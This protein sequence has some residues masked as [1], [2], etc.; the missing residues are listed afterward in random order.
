METLHEMTLTD[1]HFH[2]L[3]TVKLMFDGSGG[4]ANMVGYVVETSGCGSYRKVHG[5]DRAGAFR[6]FARQCESKILLV[7]G[8]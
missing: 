2:G 7:I 3:H 5:D 4:R 8:Y 1:P 6:N